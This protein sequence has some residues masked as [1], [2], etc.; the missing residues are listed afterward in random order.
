M[1]GPFLL[2]F[3]VDYVSNSSKH[4]ELGN[5]LLRIVFDRSL[6]TNITYF[7]NFEGQISSEPG[8]NPRLC[9]KRFRT[10]RYKY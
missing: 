9:L 8:I 1:S 5:N 3:L 7:V 4:C 10:G 2:T 6:I